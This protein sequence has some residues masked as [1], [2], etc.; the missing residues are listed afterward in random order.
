MNFVLR[1]TQKWG[2]ALQHTLRTEYRRT[3]Y[4]ENNGAKLRMSF[5]EDV[6]LKDVS[7]LSWEQCLDP[8]VAVPAHKTFCF[9]LGI[10]E[11]KL[12]FA[13][14]S[15]IDS[16]AMPDWVYALQNAGF[17]IQVGHQVVWLVCRR[18]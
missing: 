1:D 16:L 7:S 6:T 14:F 5:D 13:C 18:F 9:P 15:E 4:Q 2:G 8:A 3:S 17:I 11:V 12:A 10:L